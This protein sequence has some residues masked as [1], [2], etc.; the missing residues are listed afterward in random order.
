MNTKK[1]NPFLSVLKVFLIVLIVLIAVIAIW[2][3]FS[4]FNKKDVISLLP[5]DYSVYI[6]TESLWDA[7]NPIIDLQVADVILSAP[8][9]AKARGALISFRQSPLRNNKYID[10]AAS[11]PV[12]VGI[13]MDENVPS[14]LGIIDMGVF[15]AASRLA[16]G[17]L[18][19]FN[20]KGL[21]LVQSESNYYFEYSTPEGETVAYIKPYYNMIIFSTNKELLL[22]SCAKLPSK[23][24]IS[25]SRSS[26]V[27][28]EIC[29]YAASRLLELYNAIICFFLSSKD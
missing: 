14:I 26:S 25:K 5:N 17:V 11:R 24:H 8:E 22:K 9:M 13:Y 28:V 16:K 21:S 4:A 27:M 15:S 23:Y 18:P 29:L 12:D 20:V 3:T 7:L 1:K 10:F 19:M 2:C 6:K